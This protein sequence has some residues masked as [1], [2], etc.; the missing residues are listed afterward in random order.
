[1]QEV[2][3]DGSLW[4][5]EQNSGKL[6]IFKDGELRYRNVLKS[7]HDGHHHL[8]NWTRILTSQP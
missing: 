5:E 1:M 7:H 4:I 2:L 6:W 3:P 8:P